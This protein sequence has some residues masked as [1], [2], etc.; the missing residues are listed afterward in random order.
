ANHLGG[1][2]WFAKDFQDKTSEMVQEEILTLQEAMP[3][4]LFMA[5]DEEGGDVTRV[6]SFSQFREVPFRSPRDEFQSNGWDGIEET[7]RASA[8]LLM[9]LGLNLNLAPVVDVPTSADDFIFSRS[10]STNPTEVATYVE[11]VVTI[12]HE[13]GVG[14]VLKHFPGY[15]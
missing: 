1:Y 15:G 4:D 14:N 2:L 8:I 7:A 9:D 11:R 5:V 10:F 12:Y 6:S 13:E 3:I